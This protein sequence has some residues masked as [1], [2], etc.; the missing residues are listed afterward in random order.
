[1]ASIIRI[2]RSTVAGNPS[3]LGVGELAYSALADNGSNGG[4]RLYIGMGSP[5]TAGNAQSH[6]VI[7]G[8]YFTDMVTNATDANTASTLVKRDASGNFAAGTIT[9][10]LTGNAASATKW[11]TG[12]TLALTGDVGYTSPSFDG[13]GNVTAVATLANTAVTAGSYGFTV[14]TSAVM[15]LELAMMSCASS[16]S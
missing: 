15:S 7:G 3:T 4:D 16:S 12:R 5:E 1:M 2:K 13:T 10:T 6:I 8:K 11:A 14:L 9:A